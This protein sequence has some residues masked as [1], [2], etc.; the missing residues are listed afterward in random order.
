MHP[1]KIFLVNAACLL[2]V[3]GMLAS[4]CSDSKKS[5]NPNLEWSWA[6]FE[7]PPAYTPTQFV[8]FQ[9]NLI[10]LSGFYVYTWDDTG[11]VEIGYASG[12]QPSDLEVYDGKL[13][14]A[15]AFTHV[16]STPCSR[17]AAW[18]GSSWG[19]LGAGIAGGQV[20]DLTIYNN[21]LIAGGYFD[22]AGG[23]SAHKIAAWDGSSW[24]PLGYGANG[25]YNVGV[26]DNKLFATYNRV[27]TWDGSVWDTIGTGYLNGSTA[28]VAVYNNKLIIGGAF[29]GSNYGLTLN[30]VAAWDGS[31]WSALG[32]GADSIVLA[33]AVFDNRLIAGGYFATA[34]GVSAS[35]IA[36]WDGATWAPL[37]TGTNDLVLELGVWNNMLLASGKFTQAGGVD[38]L[39][40]AAWALR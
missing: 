39:G 28:C 13:I 29:Y 35:R 30:R 24:T 37:G 16:N 25:V 36:A 3:T 17:I 18:D 8:E 23:A 19:P 6:A 11:W 12:G 34:G 31:S 4:G 26:F 38:V 1:A 20:N 7:A 27:C 33:L 15:G 22:S 40:M 5:V 14:L 9:N 2:V 21:K 32:E 10:A